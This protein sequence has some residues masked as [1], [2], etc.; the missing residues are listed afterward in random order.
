MVPPPSHANPVAAALKLKKKKQFAPNPKP[1]QPKQE[2][3]TTTTT[4]STTTTSASITNVPQEILDQK[5]LLPVYTETGTGKTTQIP[6]YLREAGWTDK[7]IIAITQPRRVAAISIAKRVADEIGGQLGDEVGYCVRFDDK[8]NE[9]TRMK[10]MTDGML[11]REAMLDP[12]LSKYT[13][14]FLDEAHERTLNTDVLFGLLKQIQ[15]KRP[16]LKIIIMSATLDAELFSAYFNSAPILYIEGRQ[17]PVRIYYTEETQK[18]YVDAALVTVLQIHTSND[19]DDIEGEGGDILVFLTG[20]EEIDN[21]EKLLNERIPRL[22]ENAKKLLVCPIYSA[23]PQEQQMKVFERAPKGTRK[24]IIATNI[25]ETSLTINGI[26]YVVD[27]GVVKSR[28]YN[29]NIGLDT[30]TVIPISKASAKQRTGRAGRE[31]AGKCYRLYTEKM[32]SSLDHS[33]I[34]EIKR[35][36]IS[37]VILQLMTIG[38]KDVLSF[39]FLE[40]PPLATV[41]KS[42]EQLYTLGALTIDSELTSLGKQMAQF[43]LEPMFSKTLIKSAEFECMEEV[44]III[45]MLSVES[46]FFVPKDKKKEVDSIKKIFFSPEGDHIT[47]LN[48]FREYQKVNGSQ[49][50]CY[51]HFINTKSMIK[52]VN[53]FEQLYE[54]A[55]SFKMNITSC[56]SDTE[57][58]RRAFVTGFFMHVAVL[59]PD[60]KYRTMA[61][62]KELH[63]HPSSF[64]YD[65]QPAYIIYNELTITTKPFARNIFP[66]ESSW[67]PELVPRYFGVKKNE[68]EEDAESAG[69]SSADAASETTHNKFE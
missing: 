20:R 14:I 55:A 10:Y 3:T 13:A 35:S 28:I 36:N 8:T 65:I 37:N 69:S 2:E 6:Q 45:A 57:R 48:V 4:T 64:M 25:A 7:G 26:R 50:W 33:S 53:V 60:R 23:M 61:D 47:L 17:F 49:Q 41:Q 63:I 29:A 18:D 15:A 66:I 16:S 54:Y 44:L 30:L 43:P 27:T 31:F 34:P 46:I 68:N 56:Q 12:K 1:R 11:V 22:P 38:V 62:N 52:V 32:Y 67:L 5:K 24:V 51:D 9:N 21:L 59:Q 19:D 42:L 39:D 40:K 58:V